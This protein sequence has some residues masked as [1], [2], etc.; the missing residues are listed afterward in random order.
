MTELNLTPQKQLQRLI[1]DGVSKRILKGELCINDDVQ[2]GN[3]GYGNADFA[4]RFAFTQSLG[5]DLITLSPLSPCGL[6]RLPEIRD[7][8]WPDLQKWVR[9]TP[10]FTFAL[11]DGAFEWGM[12]LL[13]VTKFCVMLRQSPLSLQEIVSRVEAFNTEMVARL[14]DEGIDGIILAD[15]IAH[16]SGLFAHPDMLTRTFIPSLARQVEKIRNCN[17]PVFYH[18]DGNYNLVLE[19]IVRTGFTG[20]QCLEKSAN[21]DI[22]MIRKQFGPDLCL[23]GHLDVDDIVC[24]E[25]ANFHQEL[26]QSVQKHAAEGK[27]ILGTT[28]GLFQGMDIAKVTSLYRSVNTSSERIGEV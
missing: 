1:E 7:Y 16:Q 23:W 21:M 6:D 25:D 22:A 15:D 3:L 8:Q 10:L 9:E 11:L 24:V 4:E 5:L 27:F 19:D 17:L 28:S 2:F 20:L 12:K 13:G 18:S 14:T 26:V